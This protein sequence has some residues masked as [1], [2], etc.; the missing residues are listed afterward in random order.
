MEQQFAR[1]LNGESSSFWNDTEVVG[2][3]EFE[4]RME[5]KQSIKWVESSPRVFLSWLS[6]FSLPVAIKR[7]AVKASTSELEPI[8]NAIAE[9][10]ALLDLDDDWDEQGSPRYSEQTWKR[11]TKFLSKHA[12]WFW[13]KFR[14]RIPAPRIAPGPHGSIDIYWKN[15]SAELLV[16]VPVDKNQPLTCYGDN[17]NGFK[18]SGT[19]KDS[20]YKQGLWLWLNKGDSEFGQRSGRE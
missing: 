20:D 9:S 4:F 13:T 6:W 19:L 7:P 1:I 12:L 15:D 3:E 5:A 18:M 14:I 8:S 10:R 17:K 16:N 11:A 2:P